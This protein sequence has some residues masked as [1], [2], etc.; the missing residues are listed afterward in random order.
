LHFS[1][2]DV[3]LV[4]CPEAEID[5]FESLG[6]YNAVDPSWSLERMI[7]TIVKKRALQT[8]LEA[9]AERRRARAEAKA[10][11]SEDSER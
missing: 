9:V 2:D 6:S 7:E 4:L 1:W 10:A 11:A 3:A 5:E 8:E